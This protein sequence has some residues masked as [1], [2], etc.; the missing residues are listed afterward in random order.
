MR[1]A[2]GFNSSSCLVPSSRPRT[3]LTSRIIKNSR[4]STCLSIASRRRRKTCSERSV[5]ASRRVVRLASAAKCW[6]RLLLQYRG[7]R[8]RGSISSREARDQRFSTV[9]RALSR[10]A[11]SRSLV[12]N[13]RG[14]EMFI[15]RNPCG[16]VFM[17]A[18]VY[19]YLG[20][21]ASAHGLRSSLVLI[22]SRL[23]SGAGQI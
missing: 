2:G 21:R 10:S 6:I 20:S 3:A 5:F 4:V 7:R 14:C 9:V 22:S 12:V 11:L 13:G 16:I 17:L 8:S 15:L 1:S 18:L 19:G 23:C